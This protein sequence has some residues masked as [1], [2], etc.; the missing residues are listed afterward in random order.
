[1]PRGLAGREQEAAETARVV[2]PQAAPGIE[3]EV[4]VVVHERRLGGV[5]DAKAPRHAEVQDQRARVG[6]DEEVL[7]APADGA[8]ARACELRR[9]RPRHAPAQAPLAHPERVDPPAD[10]P[11]LDAP[12]RR[13][14][15]G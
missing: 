3:H 8:D 12:A 7:R 9:Q 13:F 1:M 4:E 6:L 10:E 15:L 2:E 14:Y 11:G 5:E